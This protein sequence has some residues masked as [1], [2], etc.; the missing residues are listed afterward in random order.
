MTEDPF[1]L[2][3]EREIERR[4]NSDDWFWLLFWIATA[5]LAL[6]FATGCGDDIR[7]LWLIRED[8]QYPWKH[9]VYQDIVSEYIVTIKSSQAC[10]QLM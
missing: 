3:P 1:D 2:T 8:V 6:G 5:M 7:H 10:P 4:P 9:C